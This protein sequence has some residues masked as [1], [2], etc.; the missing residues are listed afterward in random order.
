MS[1]IFRR[2]KPEEKTI[3]NNIIQK[4]TINQIDYQTI[5]QKI[6]YSSGVT[7]IT[8]PLPI[9]SIFLGFTCNVD[10]VKSAS[11]AYMQARATLTRS[12][13]NSNI[14]INQ[15]LIDGRIGNSINGSILI[16]SKVLNYECE[17]P[18]QKEGIELEIVVFNQTQGN[19]FVDVNYIVENLEGGI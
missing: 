15:R 9:N 19:N 14:R 1:S 18:I 7:T 2:N 8:I 12:S 11:N 13:N 3:I 10:H 16:Y 6:N 5:S 17:I 4:K